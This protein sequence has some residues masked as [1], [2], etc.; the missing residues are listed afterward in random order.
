MPAVSSACSVFDA[1]R[2]WA[3]CW[4]RF[5]RTTGCPSPTSLLSDRGKGLLCCRQRALLPTV[6]FP[7]RSARS[8]RLGLPRASYSS[9]AAFRRC[10]GRH[11][12]TKTSSPSLGGASA[13]SAAFTMSCGHG[14]R[15]PLPSGYPRDGPKI[16]NPAGLV[17]ERR[18]RSG[19]V[20]RRDR[21]VEQQLLR[22]GRKVALRECR[23]ERAVTAQQTGRPPLGRRRRARVS[24]PTDR[25][26]GR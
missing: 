3:A 19:R 16:G 15:S 13:A 7:Q 6:V 12:V 11:W 21:P 5:A 24:Y 2:T 18:E 10:Q 4:K 17:I 14:H 23:F 1:R 9:I 25:H 22:L 8:G 26:G 20:H